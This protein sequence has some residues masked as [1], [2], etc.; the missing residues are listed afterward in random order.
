M[1]LN[2]NDSDKKPLMYIVQPEYAEVKAPMQHF[3]KKK[4]KKAEPEK[5]EKNFEDQVQENET[6]SEEENEQ[7]QT[8]EEIAEDTSSVEV[9]DEK[10][11]GG[12]L[13]ETAGEQ[14]NEGKRSRKPL[15]HM[16]IE[17]RLEFLTRLPNNIP[18]AL[19]MIETEEKTYRGIILEKKDGVVLIKTSASGDP[20]R[21]QIESIKSIHPLG[22]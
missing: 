1:T 16:N 9:P 8:E 22:F 11:S 15:N 17:E 12:V 20:E 3:V 14:R 2:N 5:P 19:C 4:K 7:L 21:I 6:A 13:S 10:L 18:K